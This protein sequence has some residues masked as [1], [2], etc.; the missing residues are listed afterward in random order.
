MPGYADG[1]ERFAG[2]VY[3]DNYYIQ[4]LEDAD[5]VTSLKVR[6]VGADG[7][8]SEA[9]V[10]NLAQDNRVSNILTVSRDNALTVTWTEPAGDFANVEVSPEL[11]VQH[12]QGRP[13]PG[14]RGQGRGG[15]PASRWTWRTAA[16]TF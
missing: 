7:S 13:R 9:A 12:R 5:N 6:A 11:L 16:G 8:E 15:L 4:T 10:V 14:H 1:T 3:G 2:G